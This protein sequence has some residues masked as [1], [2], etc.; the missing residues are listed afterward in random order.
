M[1]DNSNFN[2]RCVLEYPDYADKVTGGGKYA[3]AHLIACGGIMIM[4]Y[5][6]NDADYPGV[7]SEM[8]LHSWYDGTRF[9]GVCAGSDLTNIHSG[10]DSL[11]AAIR[12]HWQKVGISAGPQD[13]HPRERAFYRLDDDLE[14]SVRQDDDRKV[15]Q[16]SEIEFKV[17]GATELG[18]GEFV[19]EIEGYHGFFR[20]CPK[21][22]RQ[23]APAEANAF[24]L[25]GDGEIVWQDGNPTHHKHAVAYYRANVDTTLRIPT[26]SDVL[27][28]F[29]L[30]MQLTLDDL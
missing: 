29:D 7:V 28:N 2:Y 6:G 27:Q 24:Q 13:S 8:G 21:D 17:L 30:T 15:M 26:E 12:K 16:S 1:N 22:I 18:R 10:P 20:Y 9:V 11:R 25:V 5:G 4:N 19:T 23:G 3:M 14:F